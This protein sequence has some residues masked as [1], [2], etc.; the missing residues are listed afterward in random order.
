[1][2][3]KK[4]SNKKEETASQSK[5]QGQSTIKT[6]TRG[7][8]TMEDLLAQTGYQLKGLKRGELVEGFI[9]RLSPREILIDVGGK[10]E[11]IVSNREIGLI[12][13]LT[14]NLKVG[15]KVNAYVISPESE[16]GQII[17][18]LRKVGLD[19]KWKRIK[20]IKEKEEIITVHVVEVKRNGLIAEFEGIHG[21]VPT[22]QLELAYASKPHELINKDIQVRVLEVEQKDNRLIF[23]QKGAIGEEA[24]AKLKER[25]AQIKIGE[26]Y[27][28]T[29]FGVT[30]FGLFI[31][32]DGV[33]GLVHISEI[34]WEKI[35]DPGEYFKVGDKVKVLVL[36]VDEKS[37]RLN[38]SIK[39]LTPDPYQELSKKY[40]Q[41]E[42][43]KG[44]ITRITSFGVF[45][46]LE[47]GIEGLIHIS[48][49]PPEKEL[50]VDEEIE[51][52][53]ESINLEQRKIS[54]TLVLKEKPIGYK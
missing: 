20:E 31:N 47:K 23:S 54:L 11:G 5:P 34:A 33:E 1:M 50:K 51:C 49:I 14:R 28:G 3:L 4:K 37:A 32:I 35:T 43:I 17:L 13:D 40:S 41:G 7:P 45:V 30:H 22:S 2:S 48:K 44:K 15:D 19:Y 12:A 18:S 9:T 39:Q 26:T 52:L 25:F 10:S 21:F 38:L 27:E 29:V 53:V 8:Q 42:L 46:K 36:G 24:A 16:S 6:S